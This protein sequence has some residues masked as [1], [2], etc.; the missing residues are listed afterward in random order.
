[1]NEV[2][3]RQKKPYVVPTCEV[4]K[5]EG[6]DILNGGII[7]A[8]IKEPEDGGEITDAKSF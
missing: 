5:L 8:S 6:G 1:M 4:I 2:A 7:Q 3:V